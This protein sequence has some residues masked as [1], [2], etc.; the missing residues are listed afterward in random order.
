MARSEENQNIAQEKRLLFARNLRS[1]R[2]KADYTQEEIARRSNLTQSF[3]SDVENGKSP[4]SLDNAV[5]LASAVGS[6]ICTLL[7]PKKS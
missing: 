5:V 4:I 6:S 3:I 2:I 7:C 1:A